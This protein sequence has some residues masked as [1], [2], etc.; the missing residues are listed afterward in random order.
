MLL[1]ISLVT[2]NAIFARSVTIISFFIIIG[3]FRREK[4]LATINLSSIISWFFLNAL[5]MESLP[6]YEMELGVVFVW[7][8]VC[9]R[10]IYY[11]HVYFCYVWHDGKVLPLLGLQFRLIKQLLRLHHITI[12]S[13]ILV[14]I[15]YVYILNFLL[16]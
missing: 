7:I 10:P 8:C 16:E 12:L 9:F 6:L 2:L 13:A 14:K 5:L 1:F 3:C 11:R 15:S 4:R